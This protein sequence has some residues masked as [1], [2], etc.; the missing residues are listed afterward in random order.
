[1]VV[2]GSRARDPRVYAIV[3]VH[4]RIVQTTAFCNCLSAQTY[5]NFVLVL[6]DD[7]STDGTSRI[8]SSYA[9][10]KTIVHGGGS[11]WWAGGLRCG[12]ARVLA[13]DPNDDDIVWFVNNDTSFEA[14]FL[15]K[16]VQ[17]L[18]FAGRGAM[19]AVP[20]HF[21]DTGRRAEG[22]FRCYWPHFTF[23]DY[24]RHPEKIDCASTRSLLL[25][26]CD[27][28]ESGG[29]RPRLLPHY[30][31]DL[32]FTIR[33][34]RHSIRIVPAVSVICS[35]IEK[36][37]GMHRVPVGSA[38]TVLRHMFSNRFSA[39]PLHLF[40]FVL[41]AVP[42]VWKPVCWLFAARSSMSCFINAAILVRLGWKK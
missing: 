8:V 5:R 22:G 24:G 11:L 25:R 36:S 32:E 7:G 30:L 23:R 33:A 16:A 26:W 35:S 31:S 9:F 14:N 28:M 29:F 20:I 40:L 37:T 12:L 34:H 38:L 2:A 18:F 6:V 4:D 27:V 17:E 21:T 13:Q 42:L 3:P 15:E 10:P 39:N 1:M 19:L 41:L